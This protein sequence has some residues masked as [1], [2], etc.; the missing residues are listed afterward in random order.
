MLIN[1]VVL[2]KKSCFG[3]FPQT[4]QNL[5]GENVSKLLQEIENR[6]REGEECK[7]REG[8]EIIYLVIYFLGGRD[9]KRTEIF[10][11]YLGR[12]LLL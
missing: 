5:C 7:E 11:N 4:G 10:C 9:T 8:E 3:V 2:K 1:S 12:T 6:E